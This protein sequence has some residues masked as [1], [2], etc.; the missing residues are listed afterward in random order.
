M[1]AQLRCFWF[2]LLL[3]SLILGA[4][5]PAA[6]PT[7]Q[8]PATSA[9]QA[10]A[11]QAP[12]E[13]APAPTEAVQPTAAEP[14]PVTTGPKKG[15]RITLIFGGGYYTLDPYQ[16]S[17]SSIIHDS[18][19]DRLVTPSLDFSKYVPWLAES[20]DIAPDNLTITFHL[21]KD[22][23]FH[24]GTPVNA[25][26][27]K[28][29]FD[30]YLDPNSVATWNGSWKD[31]FVEVQTP[32][33]YTVAVKLKT[34]YAPLFSDLCL[35]YIVSPTAYEKEG[36][37]NFGM[38]P[39]GSGPWI[40]KEIAANDH[41]LFVRNPDY[42]W[43]PEI[44]E[45]QGPVYPDELM[46]RF[47]GDEQVIYASL[48]TGEIQFATLP[49]QFLSLAEQNKDI[50][51]VQGIDT[52]IFYLG[53]NTSQPPLNDSK[54]RLAIASAIN[55]DEII[56]TGYDGKAFPLYVFLSPST[57]GFN[58]DTNEW[59]KTYQAYDPEKA[60]TMLSELG[61]NLGSDGV[62]VDKSGKPLELTLDFPVG[63]D[64]KR[65]AETIQGQLQDVG[66]KLQM[67]QLEAGAIAEKLT[68]CN[69]QLFIR[70]TGWVDPSV[71]DMAFNSRNIG[72]I[73]R[74]CY[75]DKQMDQMLEVTN[76]TMDLDKRWGAVDTALRYLVDQRPSIPLWS[77]FAYTAYRSN[78]IQGLKFDTAAY[79]YLMDAYL[80][81]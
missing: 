26:A 28:W 10:A 31:F 45:N 54:F 52:S 73:N 50:S 15:G 66:I 9:P 72:A 81:Q 19:Y 58:K 22:A 37:D 46:V 11:T 59:A 41:I 4:C 76:T 80:T 79:Y 74:V 29:N 36:M 51:I 18:M 69:M 56:Q 8:P 23:K 75:N 42:H 53:T 77:P 33:E 71:I 48:E 57:P 44:F 5:T 43:A 35:T 3:F 40:P 47:L 7:A 55:R 27:I 2:G 25:A 61:Y 67:N 30:K 13:V 62:M 21:R 12:T 14:A 17:A 49:A 24:D 60:K 6:T 16:T 39:I 34:P 68:K 32:D 1:K 65:V 38:K 70:Y 78:D 20:W 64:I 63:D